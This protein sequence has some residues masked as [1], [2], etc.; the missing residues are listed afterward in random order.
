MA[1]KKSQKTK[2]KASATTK[3]KPKP[4]TKKSPSKAPTKKRS[5][6]A[7]VK[8]KKKPKEKAKKAPAKK[9]PAKPA[10]PKKKKSVH[11][12]SGKV[13]L[14]QIRDYYE[15]DESVTI[16]NDLG[17]NVY[18]IAKGLSFAPNFIN[19]SYKDDMI[20]D[21]IVKMFSALQQHKFKVDSGYN[22]FSYFT[23]IAYHAFINRIKKEK[24]HREVLNEYQETVYDELLGSDYDDVGNQPD[25]TNPYSSEGDE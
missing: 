11:Y 8:P 13:L 23:T 7:D 20:G 25:F 18:K 10:K 6:P 4:V 21:A 2:P 15:M 9:A 24:K 12:V 22:P 17:E 16:P 5:K 19:Y 14:Q 3:S 1:S